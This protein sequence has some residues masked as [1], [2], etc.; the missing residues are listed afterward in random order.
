MW[1]PRSSQGGD[2]SS[3]AIETLIDQ[4]TQDISAVRDHTLELVRVAHMVMGPAI[5]LG[6]LVFFPASNL[7]LAALVYLS[8][9]I[10]VLGLVP[11]RVQATAISMFD[12]L[13]IGFVGT[14]DPRIWVAMLVPAAAAMTVGWLVGPRATWLLYVAGL[15]SLAAAGYESEP[16]GW[17]VAL[18]VFAGTMGVVNFNNLKIMGQGR[19]GALKV[20]DLVDSLPVIVW[21]SDPTTGRFTH[22]VGWIEQLLG[23][24]AEEWRA[25]PVGRRVDRSDLHGL[26]ESNQWAIETGEAVTHE[27]RLR[28]ADGSSIRVRE[29]VRRVEANGRLWLRGVVLDIEEEAAAREAVDR[30]AAVVAHQVEPLLVLAPRDGIEQEPMVLQV[31]PAF[32]SM[33]AVDVADA[34]G[35]EL[36]VIAPWLPRTV[37]ADLD[38]FLTTG[39]VVDRDDIEIH[40][41]GGS[42][43]FDYG[44]VGLPDGSVAV[45]FADVTD[46][47]QATELIRHQAFHDPLTGLPN[48][49]LLFDRLAHALGAMQRD[50][51]TIGLLL[52]DLNQ[53]K[54]INDTLGHAYGDQ[55]LEV[56]GERLRVMTREIDTVARLGG[57]EFAMVVSGAGQAQLGEIAERVFDSVR[58]PVD[59]GGIEVEVTASVGGA[60]APL[61]GTDAHTLL[62]RADVAMYDAKGSGVPFRLYAADDDRHS[63]DR[64]ALM[65][66]L[67]NLLDDQLRVWFQPKID[68]RTGQS[69]GVE[70][71]ARWEHPRLGLLG[72]GKFIEL[73]EISGIIA[74]LTFRV[75][76]VT[77]EAMS[78]WPGQEVAVNVPV[79]NLYDRALPAQ[80]ME[81]L[82]AHGVAPER[83]ILEITEREIMEDHRA[84]S[85]V[86]GALDQQGVRISIDDFGT[87]FSSLTHLRRLPISE[88]KIDQSFIRGML[89]RENDY[90][91]ARS[92]IDL[93]HNLG[94]RVVAEGVE[95]TATLD[96]L[97]GLGCDVAQ[98]FLFSRP[99]PVDRI[100]RRIDAGPALDHEGRLAWT[101]A[102]G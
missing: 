43:T 94:H 102:A 80:V 54:E 22:A 52:L 27:F 99:G 62:Q 25:L 49:T 78:S 70:A 2:G 37:R 97:R 16:R 51:S 5:T 34:V 59:L 55:L 32:G 57:D 1:W 95:D 69:V 89:D 4:W 66:E 42:R 63:L 79:R 39:R 56:I 28:C 31:N 26:L 24:T 21:E 30:L 50:G 10:A 90:I 40:I 48:R 81:K 14:V 65:G 84:I 3:P 33:A 86:L 100:R 36:E 77:L 82:A 58:R 23:F 17:P 44:I 20:A 83:L 13:L 9:L 64:L 11:R 61:D 35:R 91:I 88:I 96:L 60:V 75:L 53:F 101:G 46:R 47:K 71:L 15:S 19:D 18:A 8:G 72:P 38:D 93:A 73:C 85:D 67:R 6:L 74:E 29:V 12:L 41:P 45:Q 98:G 68:L 76:D 92:I 7:T 87:G